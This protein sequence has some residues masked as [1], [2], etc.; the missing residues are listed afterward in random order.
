MPQP[1][2]QQALDRA[3]HTEGYEETTVY[4]ST[5]QYLHHAHEEGKPLLVGKEEVQS[6]PAPCLRPLP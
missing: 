4:Y 3:L 6:E 1:S 2:T 5:V